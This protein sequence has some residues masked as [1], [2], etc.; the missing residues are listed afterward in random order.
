MAEDLWGRAKH[1][2]YSPVGAETIDPVVWEHS[3]RVARLTEVIAA[4]PELARR[5]VDRTA[6]TAAALYHDAGWVL[7][8]RAGQ[9]AP[10]ELLCR[11]TSDQQ[12]EQAANWIADRLEGIQ[13]PGG[14]GLTARIILGCN[15][16]NI[17]L[18]EAQILAEAENLDEIGPQTVWHMVR[19][20]LAEGRTLA[21]M[22]EA[23]Q[24]QE[25]YNYWP[26][27]IKECFRFPSVRALADQRLQTM[28]RFMAELQASCVMGPPR[29]GRPQAPAEPGP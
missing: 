23:W 15:D 9:I 4:V 13:P 16:R 24:R 27:W 26:T 20:Q 10:G 29:V 11:R 19:R 25:Q 1:D 3:L 17:D 2:L 22:I 6:L 28:R 18:L 21:D 5:V 12:R 14:L 7:Q 8:L